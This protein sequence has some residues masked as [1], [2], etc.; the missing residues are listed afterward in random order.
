MGLLLRL[1]DFRPRGA[2]RGRVFGGLG[3]GPL[4]TLGGQLAGPF[5][6]LIPLAQHLPQGLEK[7][8]LQIE[9]EQHYEQKCGYRF[10]QYSAQGLQHGIH[11]LL[12]ETRDCLTS[13]TG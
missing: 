6:G 7:N 5:R 4:E 9:V 13:R 10:Q 8:A 11:N 2:H 12:G 1:V 3:G